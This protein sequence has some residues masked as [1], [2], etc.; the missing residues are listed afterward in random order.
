M[1]EKFSFHNPTQ[2]IRARRLGL[3]IPD[4][5]K[6]TFNHRI[7]QIIFVNNI[8]LPKPKSGGPSVFSA[9]KDHWF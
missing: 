1:G 2:K 3:P 4:P 5:K 7:A 9:K 6:G 8:P